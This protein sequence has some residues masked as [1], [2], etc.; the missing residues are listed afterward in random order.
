[1]ST[2]LHVYLPEKLDR[3][4]RAMAFERGIS[5]SAIIQELIEAAPAPDGK[6]YKEWLKEKKK[7]ASK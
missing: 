5:M 1:M 4:L 2:T 3:K 6:W 7:G